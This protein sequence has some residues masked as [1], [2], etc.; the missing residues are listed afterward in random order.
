MRG[1]FQKEGTPLFC[2]I[3]HSDRLEAFGYLNDSWEVVNHGRQ[4]PE[5]ATRDLYD[6]PYHRIPFMQPGQVLAGSGLDGDNVAIEFSK[7]QS[8]RFVA[9]PSANQTNIPPAW[10]SNE[11]PNPIRLWPNA[12]TIIGYPIV[13]SWFGD[14]DLPL[15]ITKGELSAN[16]EPVKVYLNTPANDDKLRQ[17]VIILP[18]EPLKPLTTYKVWIEGTIGT[19]AFSESWTFTTGASKQP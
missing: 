6:A 19:E 18:Q 13:L 10:T 12:H 7:P 14:E 5:A 9:A 15:T 11:R 16:G 8:G 17:A 3:S 1:H 4:D 2:G